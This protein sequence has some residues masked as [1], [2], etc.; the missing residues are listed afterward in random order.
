MQRRKPGE[1]PVSY[2]IDKLSLNLVLLGVNR[3]SMV[4]TMAQKETGWLRSYTD[5]ATNKTRT[6]FYQKGWLSTGDFQCDVKE[7]LVRDG[8]G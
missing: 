1:H 8:V 4:L 2:D 7:Y 6:M 3:I 5:K